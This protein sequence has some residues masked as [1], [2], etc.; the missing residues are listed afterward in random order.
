MTSTHNGKCLL[1]LGTSHVE[2][3]FFECQ[4]IALIAVDEEKIMAPAAFWLL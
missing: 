2:Q 3:M 4:E 1:G